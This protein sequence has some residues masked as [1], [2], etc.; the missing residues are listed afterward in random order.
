M[1][2]LTAEQLQT[3]LDAI[4]GSAVRGDIETELSTRDLVTDP[5]AAVQHAIDEGILVA[6]GESTW[7][8]LYTVAADSEHSESSIS[9]DK[10]PEEAGSGTTTPPL[11]TIQTVPTR[12]GARIHRITVSCISLLTRKPTMI[13]R[14]SHTKRSSKSSLTTASATLSRF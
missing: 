5:V 8:E 3:V 1:K 4:G 7:G 14:G 2:Y 12:S 9:A 13:E 11:T 10:N 6:N